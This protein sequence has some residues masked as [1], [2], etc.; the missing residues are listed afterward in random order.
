[1][2]IPHRI[3]YRVAQTGFCC[4]LAPLSLG[5]ALAATPPP[6]STPP[7]APKTHVLFM[8]ADIS[9]KKDKDFHRV[10]DVTP[11]ALVISP[12]GR[13]VEVPLAQGRDLL[14]NESL[15]IAETR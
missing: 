3:V 7:S 8:G 10:E 15:K 14:I 9:L 11:G 12:G 4:A 5:T 6:A 13:R 1:M 2:N